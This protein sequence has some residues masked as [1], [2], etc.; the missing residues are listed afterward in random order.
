M[1]A[2]DRWDL[3]VKIFVRIDSDKSPLLFLAISIRG[4][5]WFNHLQGVA[6]YNGIVES[7][8]NNRLNTIY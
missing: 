3:P 4:S 2:K 1:C 6:R 7:Y 5:S 8:D